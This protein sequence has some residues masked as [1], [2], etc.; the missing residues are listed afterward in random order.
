M[1]T[2]PEVREP[3]LEGREIFCFFGLALFGGQVIEHVLLT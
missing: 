3:P 2:V 1:A